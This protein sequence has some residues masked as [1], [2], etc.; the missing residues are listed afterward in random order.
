MM[1]LLYVRSQQQYRFRTAERVGHQQIRWNQ[2]RDHLASENVCMYRG[3]TPN[4]SVRECCMQCVCVPYH[5]TDGLLPVRSLSGMDVSQLRHNIVFVQ[6][7][8][9]P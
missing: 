7:T 5:G 4:D 3:K 9:S 6:V 1:L 2:N 8:S